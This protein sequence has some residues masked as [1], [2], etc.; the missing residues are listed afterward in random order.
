VHEGDALI[1]ALGAHY[2]MDATPGL[3]EAGNEFYS[4]AG[5]E[6]L[7]GILPTFSRGHALIGGRRVTALD[8][9]RS[10]AILDDETELAFDLFLG[11]PKH[12]APMS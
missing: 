5:A 8:P 9:G 11:V 2:D 7:A 1:I 12:R 3:A 4:F 10:V 6:R